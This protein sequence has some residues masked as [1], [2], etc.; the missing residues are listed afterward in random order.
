MADSHE[1]GY[2]IMHSIRRVCPILPLTANSPKTDPSAFLASAVNFCLANESQCLNLVTSKLLSR[3]FRL[4]PT[5]CL[6]RRNKALCWQTFPLGLIHLR[7]NSH[8]TAWTLRSRPDLSCAVAHEQTRC[9]NPR[10]IDWYELKHIEGYL[11]KST[12][13]GI[14]IDIDSLK[15]TSYI[16]CDWATH[17]NRNSRSRCLNV[18]VE[19][20]L[21]PVSWK[22]SKQ[23]IVTSSST[24]G[25]LVTL[26]DMADSVLVMCAQL[27]FYVGACPKTNPYHAR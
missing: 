17:E 1:T 12:K 7:R 22:S 25:K 8:K 11:N 15:L 4:G 9:S 13:H 24:E 3:T 18:L 14:I 5:E 20:R 6:P 16:D 21:V 27:E 10:V 2:Y 26:S 19:K 23:K